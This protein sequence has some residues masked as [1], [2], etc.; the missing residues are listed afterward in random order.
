MSEEPTI[1]ENLARLR[2][3]AGLTQ[4]EL[5]TRSGVG[6]P[7][8]RGLER[9]ART[10]ALMGTLTKLAR[11]LDVKPSVLLGQR[12]TLHR[13]DAPPQAAIR[14]L[15]RAVHPLEGLPGPQL[16]EQERGALSLT[17][18]HTEVEDAWRRY[19]DGALSEMVA[20]LPAFLSAARRAVEDLRGA[21]RRAA[22]AA[23]ARGYQAAAWGAAH[24]GQDDLARTA[25]EKSLSAAQHADDPVLVAG[26]WNAL[27]WILLR[28]QENDLVATVATR[29]ARQLDPLIS[30]GDYHAVRMY[31]R[32]TLSAMTAAARMDDHGT[33]H[34]LLEAARRCTAVV[35]TDTTDLANGAH[36]AAF[37]PS[38]VT[39]L[40]VEL[41][42]SEQEPAEALR[43]ARNVPPTRC[44]PPVARGR[45]LLDVA[46]AHTWRGQDAEAVRALGRVQAMAPEWMRHQ[47]YARELVRRLQERKGSRRLPGLAPL[48]RHMNLPG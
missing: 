41:A 34:E 30:R 1:G 16:A 12:Q 47:V 43:L 32:L 33:A 26:A 18:L 21:D 2:R 24:L 5:A 44:I 9:N 19:W 35:S 4:V 8:I 13:D 28:Q 15:R 46:Q 29:A 37:G 38:L 17:D 7:T 22:R 45:H 27:A 23:L 36:H 10:T 39:M 6:L 11:T 31:G 20:A 3:Q 25:V 48:A 40:G 42:I 14:A